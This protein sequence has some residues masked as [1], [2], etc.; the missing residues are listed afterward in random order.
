MK[1]VKNKT[2]LAEKRCGDQLQKYIKKEIILKTK[3]KLKNKKKKLEKV[4]E[5]VKT[6]IIKYKN[7]KRQQKY[8][9]KNDMR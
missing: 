5:I 6:T 9:R 8:R 4:K 3:A 1:K 2:R 7:Q